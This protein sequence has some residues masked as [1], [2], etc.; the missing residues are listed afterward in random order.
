M[1]N[2]TNDAWFGSTIGPFQHFANSKFRAVEEGKHLI[3]VANT[4]IS[5]S[6]DPY[7]RVLNKLFLNTSNYFDTK[8]FVIKD[9][10]NNRIKTIYSDYKN[11]LIIILLIILFFLLSV[12]KYYFHKKI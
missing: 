2:I 12:L 3:R 8:V 10:K 1:I 9:N 5:A 7:G 11:N 6:I 4:G